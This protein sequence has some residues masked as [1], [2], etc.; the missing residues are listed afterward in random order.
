VN[1]ECE[2][3]PVESPSANNCPGSANR[4]FRLCPAVS[5]KVSSR[6]VAKVHIK[7][8]SQQPNSRVQPEAVIQPCQIAVTGMV[9]A[10]S[11]TCPKPNSHYSAQAAVDAKLREG[12]LCAT[13]PL[14]GSTCPCFSAAREECS[15][16]TQFKLCVLQDADSLRACFPVLPAACR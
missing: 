12:Q 15:S 1:I 11:E 4:R 7:R 9:A 3:L 16:W 6:P 13:H 10:L 14:L 8:L 5:L 2:S